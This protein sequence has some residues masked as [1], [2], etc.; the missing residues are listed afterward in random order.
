MAD[1][2]VSTGEEPIG[3]WVWFQQRF[4]ILMENDTKD[5][6]D[7]RI[8]ISDMDIIDTRCRMDNPM[9]GDLRLH[10]SGI[11]PRSEGD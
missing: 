8:G 2:Q 3:R 10:E 4:K 9:C 6:E 1:A 11:R 7:L 5:Q